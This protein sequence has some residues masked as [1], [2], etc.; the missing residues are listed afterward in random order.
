M[1]SK[2]ALLN[3]I[4][5]LLLQIVSIISAFIVPRLLIGT[6]GSAVN[7]LAV[8]IS[9]FLGYLTLLQS[10]VGGVVKASLYKPLVNNDIHLISGIIKATENFFRKIAYI[11]IIYVIVLMI[12]FPIFINNNFNFCYT[13]LLVLIIG[14]GTFAQYY[15]GIT[16]RILLEADQKSYVYSLIQMISTVINIIL[17]VVL[18]RIGAGIH[19]VKL[20][21]SLVYFLTPVLLNMYVK[22]RYQI[23]KDIEPNLDS[24]SQRWDGVGHTLAYFVHTK[25][26]VA[27][28]TF[29]SNL[30]LVSVY[31]VYS[32]VTNGLNMFVSSISKAVQAAFGNMYAREEHEALMRNF[33]AFEFVIHVV[34]IILFTSAAVLIIP[35]IS[36]YTKGITDIDYIRPIFSFILILGEA[37]YCLRQPYHNII[38]AAGHYRQTKKGAYL[39]AMINLVISLILIQFI[40]II[41][42]AIGT[43]LAMLYRTTDYIIYLRKNILFINLKSVAKR[44]SVSAVNVTMI[45]AL[46]NKIMWIPMNSFLSWVGYSLIVTSTAAVITIIINIFFFKN[47]YKTILGIIKRL[48]KRKRI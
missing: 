1:R 20:G 11:T 33:K 12:A 14:L 19:G 36:I 23:I 26:D 37:V 3:I 39:E 8:S 48:L 43:L 40:D 31:S 16:Y 5:S 15:F 13:G 32:L 41:G 24:I 22:K 27:L 29:F 30:S 6:F 46:T 25:A 42:V 17:V 21:S 10:G 7:G 38:I 44:I 28:L 47:E 4:F 34:T 2:K 35:F 45:L 9:Q 18:I